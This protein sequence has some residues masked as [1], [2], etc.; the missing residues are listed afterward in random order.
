[1]SVILFQLKSLF[2][3]QSKYYFYL[4][5]YNKL[6]NYYFIKIIHDRIYTDKTRPSVVWNKEPGGLFYDNLYSTKL[7]DYPFERWQ[8]DN[9]QKCSKRCSLVITC[10]P[11]DGSLDIKKIAKEIN[12]DFI[13]Q[14]I[15]INCKIN[16][17]S[18]LIANKKLSIYNKHEYVVDAWRTIASKDFSNTNCIIHAKYSI[19]HKIDKKTIE[20]AYNMWLSN[21]S[22]FIGTNGYNIH[23]N[24]KCKFFDKKLN[25][26]EEATFANMDFSIIHR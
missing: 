4:F 18:F 24:G 19:F 13:E 20:Y 9:K 15:V 22:A 6:L 14:I 11:D 17:E 2:K 23:W 21:E 25:N 3:R 10:S 5:Y 12:L 26:K 8:V 16:S 7:C 1:M